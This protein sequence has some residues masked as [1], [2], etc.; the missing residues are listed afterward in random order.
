MLISRKI[1]ML[2][3]KPI[4]NPYILN[5]YIYSV[6]CVCWK[7]PFITPFHYNCTLF[8]VYV[9]QGDLVLRNLITFHIVF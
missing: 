3:I 2:C 1:P 8:R 9:Y 4:I 6:I 7:E 5:Y